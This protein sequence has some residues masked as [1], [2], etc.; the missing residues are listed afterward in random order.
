MTG[1][2]GPGE[3]L[4][5]EL[6]DRQLPQSFDPFAQLD[7]VPLLLGSRQRNAL[8]ARLEPINVK[9]P[10]AAH[11]LGI[12]VVVLGPGFEELFRQL[13]GL[14]G[15]SGRQLLDKGKGFLFLVDLEVKLREDRGEPGLDSL[16]EHRQP[17]VSGPVLEHVA[18]EQGAGHVALPL[19]HHLRRHRVIVRV[20]HIAERVELHA[21]AQAGG[22][23]ELVGKLR[24][25]EPAFRQQSQA[26]RPLLAAL[27]RRAEQGLDGQLLKL[28]R[29]GPV[30]GIE[31]V[32]LQPLGRG[33]ANGREDFHAAVGPPGEACLQPRPP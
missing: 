12:G 27:G 17:G 25:L 30:V 5:V 29:P 23:V 31:R 18:G 26:R 21:R 13:P 32:G 7:D 15:V 3:Q 10:A 28:D 24:L 8:G 11:L 6:A 20:V 2:E 14:P 16:V 4:L 22:E 9:E 19:H 33:P 1:G